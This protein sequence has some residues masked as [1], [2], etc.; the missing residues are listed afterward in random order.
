MDA[1]MDGSEA[2]SEM[3]NNTIDVEGEPSDSGSATLQSM[4]YLDS[5]TETRRTDGH[6]TGSK[7]SILKSIIIL[8]VAAVFVSLLLY[9]VVSGLLMLFGI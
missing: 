5:D 4:G 6:F 1:G 2:D 3:V 9:Y 8:A 7:T